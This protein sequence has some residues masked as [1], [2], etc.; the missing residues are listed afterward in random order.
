ME[1]TTDQARMDPTSLA[2][3]ARQGGPVALHPVRAGPTT[4]VG[5]VLAL[6][7]VGLEALAGG[8]RVALAAS[9][10]VGGIVAGSAMTGGVLPGG[11]MP[12]P[13]IEIEIGMP[14][15]P[16]IGVDPRVARLQRRDACIERIRRRRGFC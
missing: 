6:E 16:P 4:A 5:G 7:E 3:E 1:A 15:G 13:V 9:A 12:D 8:R 2:Q 14:I 10:R 11:F